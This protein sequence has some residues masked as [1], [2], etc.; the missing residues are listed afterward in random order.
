MT[1]FLKMISTEDDAN[2]V[3]CPVRVVWLLGSLVFLGLSI[4][5]AWQEKKFDPQQFGVGFGSLMGG[6][7]ASLYFKTKGDKIHDEH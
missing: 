2:A 1:N 4:Y 3:F 7:G 6:S 5:G